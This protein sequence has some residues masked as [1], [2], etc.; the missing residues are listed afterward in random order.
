M[1]YFQYV[2]TCFFVLLGVFFQVINGEKQSLNLCSRLKTCCELDK[3]MFQTPSTISTCARV[4]KRKDGWC[5]LWEQ[6]LLPSCHVMPLAA[7]VPP[8]SEFVHEENF[9]SKK[10]HQRYLSN[11]HSMGCRERRSEWLL[12]QGDF[13]SYSNGNQR[14]SKHSHH[15]SNTIKSWPSLKSQVN[16]HVTYPKRLWNILEARGR[17]FT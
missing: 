7:C 12:A 2:F 3:N 17:F 1:T 4:I 10:Y 16:S 14:S 15:V 13:Y 11:I 5:L 6:N 9:K 8:S